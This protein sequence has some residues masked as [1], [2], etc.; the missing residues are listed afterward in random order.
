[1]AKAYMK[2]NNFPGRDTK[3]VEDLLLEKGSEMVSLPVS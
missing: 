1:V 2:Y 3:P